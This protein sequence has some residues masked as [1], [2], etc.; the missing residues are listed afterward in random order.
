MDERTDTNGQDQPMSAEDRDL[1]IRLYEKI[2]RLHASMQALRR[3]SEDL[4][5]DRQ[6]LLEENRKLR[7]RITVSTLIEDLERSIASMGVEETDEVRPPP[8]ERLYQL[9]P[10]RFSFPHFFRVADDER[11][12]TRTARRC[13]AHYLAEGAL[14]QSGA[15]LEKSGRFLGEAGV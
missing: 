15:Y 10:A 3:T 13:L 1:V 2:A 9:L 12:E 8:A 7:R 14:V 5:A 6:R 11:L 4:E